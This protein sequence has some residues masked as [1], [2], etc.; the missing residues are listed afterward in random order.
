MVGD[1]PEI[2]ILGGNQNG[3]ETFLVKSGN[4]TVDGQMHHED[5][6]Y[7]VEDAF[8]AVQKVIEIHGIV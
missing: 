6:T 2:D 8:E 4:Y 3:F 5:A 1:S 7:I